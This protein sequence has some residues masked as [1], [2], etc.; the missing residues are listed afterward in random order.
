M[1]APVTS[2]QHEYVEALAVHLLRAREQ[3]E[4]G[5]SPG[6][7]AF[8]DA[9]R[10][11]VK[12]GEGRYPRENAGLVEYAEILAADNP[13]RLRPAMERQN[14]AIVAADLDVARVMGQ[15]ADE[16][17]ASEPEPEAPTTPEPKPVPQKT[18][19]IPERPEPE[20]EP[21]PAPA[22]KPEAKPAPKRTRA[23]KEASR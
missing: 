9:F 12:W 11:L 18:A 1:I 22:K 8:T 19:Q 4:A 6:S 7:I 2:D 16:A 17:A 23:K 3:V 21:R 10:S 13:E 15:I 20:P 5:D 14:A